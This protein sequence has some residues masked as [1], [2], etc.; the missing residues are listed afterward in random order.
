MPATAREVATRLGLTKPTQEQLHEP[1]FNIVLGTDYFTT[2]LRRFGGN[3]VLALAGYNAGPGRASRWRQQWPDLPMDEL[4]E[5]VPLQE[6]RLYVKL[7]LRN[8]MLYELL[9]HNVF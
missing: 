7:I 1:Q 8:L 4:I 5:Q 2:A 9:Y 3:T 6:T